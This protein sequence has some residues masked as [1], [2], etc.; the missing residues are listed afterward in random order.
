M[1]QWGADRTHG[2]RTSAGLTAVSVV[3]DVHLARAQQLLADHQAANGLDGAAACGASVTRSTVQANHPTS[4]CGML[5]VPALR[6]TCM[7]LPK[8]RDV[9]LRQLATCGAA[10][11]ASVAPFFEAQRTR[12]KHASIHTYL[13]WGHATCQLVGLRAQAV[14]QGERSALPRI[15]T[16]QAQRAR[17]AHALAL[18]VCSARSRGAHTTTAARRA[19][20]IGSWPTGRD[21]TYSA[22][23]ALMASYCDM[24]CEDEARRVEGGRA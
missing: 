5:R 10:A 7:S 19:G 1:R 24:V 13:K 17:A 4:V 15:A 8:G 3:H 2:Q 12:R 16:A 14:L 6:M 9:S 18:A 11:R 21:L 22:L 23:A 20:G